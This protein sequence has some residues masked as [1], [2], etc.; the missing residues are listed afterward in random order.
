VG[1]PFR[2][3]LL[4]FLLTRIALGL[5]TLFVISI[6][7][8]LVTQALP[9]DTAR[10]IL[11]REATPEAIATW[12]A[13]FG[14][15]RSAW[16]Q[17]WDW[18][19]NLLRGNLGTSY[20]TE[21]PIS[22]YIGELVRNSLFLAAVGAV[23]SIP[24]S[25]AVGVFAAS[26]R[27]RPADTAV[28]SVLQIF[29]SI[30]EFVVGTLLIVM[31]ATTVTH[32][33][34]AVAMLSPGDPPWKAWKSL[35]LMVLTLTLAV[36]PYVARVMRGS[37]IEVLESDYIEMARLKGMSERKVLWRHAFPNALGPTFQVI[38]LNLA[39]LAGGI[40]LVEYLFNF[41]GIGSALREAVKSR[42]LPVIQFVGLV[43][44]GVYVVTNLLADLG[45]I[46]VTPRLRT[47]MDKR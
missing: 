9:S 12:R 47:Q 26:R 30:P 27:D 32:V 25:I 1:N 22:S 24:I 45:T 40:I 34:P 5:L 8:F 44:A 31:F 36:T 20:V 23:V 15:D 7:I 29:A 10:I 37:L 16:V 39:Y 18:L 38:A 17:Y 21:Q 19:T 11:G 6:F 46:L 41:Q 2:N 43:I 33:F 35:V 42:D 13:K 4:R 28:T 3:P 14:Q